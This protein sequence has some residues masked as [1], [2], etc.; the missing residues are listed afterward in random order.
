LNERGFAL[1]HRIK[2]SAIL[3]VVLLACRRPRARGNVAFT[4]MPE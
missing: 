3:A 1:R 2:L 4:M